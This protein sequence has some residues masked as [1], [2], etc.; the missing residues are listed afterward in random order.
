[1][2]DVWQSAAF[3]QIFTAGKQQQLTTGDCYDDP[4]K[5]LQLIVQ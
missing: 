1:V 4:M 2:I 5:K 3:T